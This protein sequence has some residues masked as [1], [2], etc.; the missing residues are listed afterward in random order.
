MQ[1]LVGRRI[2]LIIVLTGSLILL[3]GC[4][5]TRIMNEADAC[6]APLSTEPRY[7]LANTI[8]FPEG[9]VTPS[10]LANNS[11]PTQQHLAQFGPYLDLK[12][13]CQ[14]KLLDDV[15]G[16]SASKSPQYEVFVSQAYLH[17]QNYADFLT[18]TMTY[19]DF[20]RKKEQIAASS[21]Q[22]MAQMEAAQAQAEARA[23]SQSEAQAKQACM[24]SGGTSW[25]KYGGCKRPSAPIS[26]GGSRTINCTTYGNQ[27]TCRD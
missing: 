1:K 25:S 21:K 22:E 4:A 19:S 13:K 18:G 16:T 15:G 26:L 3:V 8:L 11:Y 27:T 2:R 10:M 6:T 17:W 24:A 12:T 20:F 5:R 9:G 7:A 23:E 14:R